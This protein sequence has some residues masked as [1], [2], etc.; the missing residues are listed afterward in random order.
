MFVNAWAPSSEPAVLYQTISTH[1]HSSSR[2]VGKLDF[3]P[4]AGLSKSVAGIKVFG[5]PRQRGQPGHASR[6]ARWCSRP[7]LFWIRTMRGIRYRL[8]RA[9]W[10]PLSVRIFFQYV[11]PRKRAIQHGSGIPGPTHGDRSSA[12]EFLEKKKKKKKKKT[13]FKKKKTGFQKIPGP[14]VQTPGYRTS[15]R[16]AT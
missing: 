6:L 12:T 4:K 14:G 3:Y 11:L 9:A 13:G 8:S 15:P 1:S 16:G 7:H 2:Y 10:R 5:K